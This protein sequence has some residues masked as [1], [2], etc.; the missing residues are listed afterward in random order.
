MF[1]SQDGNGWHVLADTQA[2]AHIERM[3]G[4]SSPKTFSESWLCLLGGKSPSFLLMAGWPAYQAVCMC[5]SSKIEDN[6]WSTGTGKYKLEHW[7]NKQTVNKLLH[8]LGCPLMRTNSCRLPKRWPAFPNNFAAKRN[9]LEQEL[10]SCFPKWAS[11]YAQEHSHQRKSIQK[12][13][14]KHNTHVV[15]NSVFLQLSVKLFI[16]LF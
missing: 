11:I 6:D 5:Q 3:G 2:E 4:K 7:E 15:I 1:V 10:L 8:I 12:V 13:R 9:H 16:Y 14:I